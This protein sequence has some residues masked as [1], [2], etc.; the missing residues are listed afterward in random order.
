M[1]LVRYV[2]QR[3]RLRRLTLVL[4]AAGVAWVV[5]T[6]LWAR[7]RS[8]VGDP[9]V[10]LADDWWSGHR[11]EAR[12]GTVLR[13]LSNEHMRRG[14]PVELDAVGERMVAATLAAEDKAFWEH[15][16][17]DRTAILRAVGQNVR[18]GELI[19]GASTI[20][21]Q[22]V[23]LLD[24]RGVPGERTA[25]VKIREAARAQNLEA[26]LSKAE[27]LEAYLN[28][29]P[30]GQGYVGPQAAARG[31]FGVDSRQLSWA[32]VTFLAVLPRAPSYLD[33]HGHRDRVLLRQHA[34]IDD[35]VESGMLT[36]AE[37]DR[38]RNEAI[39]LRPVVRPFGAP[40]F[41]QT[42]IAEGRFGS[43]PTT[44]T[45]LDADLQRDVEG[46]VQTQLSKLRARSAD[47]AAVLVVDNATGD[48]LAWVG[49][50]DFD[51]VSIAGQVDMVRSPRQ[52]GSTLKP[53]VYAHAFEGGMR[54]TDIVPDVPTEFVEGASNVY[55]PRNF[56]GGFLG[57]IAARDA[58]AASLNVP[59][60]RIAS[61]FEPGSLLTL[62][63]RL[64][65][66][67]LDQD[68]S[69]YGLALALGS[70]EVS[71]RELAGAYVT[72]ARGG[73]SIAL[74][75][76]SEDP[77]AEPVRV[78]D[79]Q[80]SATIADAL[81]DPMARARLLEGR[82][83]F[84]IG[85]AVALK[86]GTSSGY[87][88]TWTAG[89]TAERTVVAWVGNADGSAMHNVTGASGAGPLFADVMRRAMR[90]VATREPLW[91]AD[92]LERVDVCPL[93]GH[94]RS[95]A[96]PQAV[97]R[98]FARGNVPDEPCS[99]HRHA[100]PG[101]E[102]LTCDAEADD[103]IAV[104]PKDFDG[105]LEGLP[106]GAPGKDPHGTLWYSRQDVQQCG[107]DD[108][109]TRP[110]LQILTPASGAAFFLSHDGREGDDRV[111]LKA[112]F[113]GPRRERPRKVE[114]VVDS[115]VVATSEAPY[116]ALVAIG[117]GE[118]DVY[119]RPADPKAG[120]HFEGHS[121]TVR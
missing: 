7:W 95:D 74:R 68:A 104:L 76:T 56:H 113:T 43:G 92:L 3:A 119:A 89:F 78:L 18:A 107:G 111:E 97:S 1:S 87:R 24:T 60:V 14:Q 120:V 22:L 20:T 6:L 21:Q 48:I 33:P 106:P 5:A 52:P 69:H 105:W 75:Y 58:L 109:P 11:I 93:S 28:R 46:L 112:R 71:M 88:D 53:F 101:P 29:L 36:D 81:S 47:N 110:S 16:G 63:R 108:R 39:A 45:T 77:A 42:I 17:V 61:D 9:Q 59:V 72:L 64:G 31:Y 25:A 50:A 30:Y 94:L 103:I 102:G 34:L 54:P 10:A 91:N 116:R 65:L 13:E 32:Q 66:R 51:D 82:S 70:G 4:L 90:D 62:L 118:H 80:V 115:K 35:M 44:E 100:R 55:A 98:N 12:D 67:S 8:D 99:M 27:I 73:E 57:P 83:P 26:T 19:S 85:F 121:F 40:H 114:F 86:T 23:K 2:V 117:P 84:D 79:E 37:A 49:S 15:D 38:A 41:V 96:C